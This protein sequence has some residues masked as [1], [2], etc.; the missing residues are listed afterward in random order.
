MS[1]LR[2]AIKPIASTLILVCIALFFW[3]AFSHNWAEIRAHHFELNYPLLVLSVVAIAASYVPA[4]Y[5]WH[6]AVNSLSPVNKVTFAQSFATVNTSGLTRYVPGKVWNLAL[7]MYWLTQL[8]ISKPLV[9]YVNLINL[10][11][12]IV[13]EVILGLGYLLLS[14]DKIPLSTS[15]SLLAALL[16][17]DAC[18]IVFQS[19]IFNLLGALFNRVLKR[20]LPRWDVPKKLMWHLHVIQ[21]ASCFAF[22]I[23]AYLLSLGLGYALSFRDALLIMASLLLSEVGGILAVLSPGGL[24]VR[25]GI[26]YAMLAGAS[27]AALALILPLAVR[28]VTMVVDV[29]LGLIGL[30]LLRRFVK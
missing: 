1:R 18:V 29:L 24:G 28:A 19:Q 20:E 5:G 27:T 26:M 8:G 14:S 11:V 6:V 12:G 23:G 3:K 21:F 4:T 22:G 16:V 30:K 10:F 17:L 9:V 2:S 7:Q 25:E 15:L 13:T